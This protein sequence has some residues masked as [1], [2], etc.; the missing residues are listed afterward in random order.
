MVYNKSSLI[1][2]PLFQQKYFKTK[3]NKC[4]EPARINMTFQIKNQK[5]KMTVPY[6]GSTNNK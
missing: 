6:R 2:C 3:F 5:P 1:I 4:C